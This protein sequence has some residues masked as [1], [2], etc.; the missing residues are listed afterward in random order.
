MASANQDQTEQMN[1]T[2]FYKNL[3][4]DIR[5]KSILLIAKED[6]LCVCESLNA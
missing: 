4:D 3:A 1:P 6:E 2:E 5:L